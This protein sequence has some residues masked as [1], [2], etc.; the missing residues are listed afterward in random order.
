M[1]VAKRFQTREGRGLWAGM[2]AHS[3]MPLTNAATAAIALVLMATG[4]QK[5]W[6]IPKGG[7]Q[8]IANALAAYFQ[9]LGGIIETNRFIHSLDQLPS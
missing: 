6:P 3:M 7:S 4:H 9:H 1:A 8:S 2:A 5:G